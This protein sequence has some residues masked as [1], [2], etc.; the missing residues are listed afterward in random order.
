MIRLLLLVPLFFSL[1]VAQAAE[2][3]WPIGKVD[4]PADPVAMEQ[5]EQ[6]P[7]LE[8][9]DGT[10]WLI[11]WEG[12]KPALAASLP[13]KRATE[14]NMLPDGRV[15]SGNGAIRRAWLSDPTTEYGHAILGDGI[16]AK[17]LTVET[18]N[19]Q[20]LTYTAPGGTVF[21]DLYPRLWDLDADGEAEAWVIRAGPDGGGRLE[22]YGVHDGK[23]IRRFATDPIGHGYRWLNPIGV[24]DFTGNGQRE[25][26]LMRTPH[27]GGIMM[28]YSAA[29][30]HLEPF[31]AAP[32]LSNHAI[33]SRQLRLQWVADIDGDGLADI[34][35]PGQ[36][37]REMIAFSM[38]GGKFSVIGTTERTGH[39]ETDFAGMTLSDGGRIVLFGDDSP[40][41]RWLRLP[42]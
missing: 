31:M 32:G 27:I 6:G 4:L 1:T 23:L 7:R 33:G 15:A 14:P 29:G 9:A 17:S 37:R 3:R 18:A 12:G 20:R 5:T 36:P 10:F 21:E 40:A 13:P 2:E 24:A 30:A 19:G 25:V 35:I 34:L 42:D 39:I 41:L 26:V 11:G 28:F 38:V 8:L 22:A 16:E